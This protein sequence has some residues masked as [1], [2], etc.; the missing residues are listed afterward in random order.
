MAWE[1]TQIFGL[2]LLSAG[3]SVWF[4][5]SDHPEGMLWAALL[6]VQSIPYGAALATSMASCMPRL[7]LGVPKFSSMRRWW[8]IVPRRTPMR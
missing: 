4:F 5:G 1:E 7:N 3:A 8:H 6:L 2:L